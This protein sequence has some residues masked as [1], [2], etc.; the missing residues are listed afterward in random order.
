MV[1]KMQRRT[2]IQV[3]S[4]I[5]LLS[6][7]TILI[8]FIAYY[9]FAAFYAILGISILICVISCILL[10]EQTSAFE[11]CFNYSVLSLFIS[12]VIVAMS[13]FSEDQSFLPY[14]GSMLGIAGIN[15]LVPSLF[16][17]LRNML[18]YGTR[19]DDYPVFYR[20]HSVL[21][22]AIYLVV[23][24]YTAFVPGAVPFAYEGSLT[25][26][27]FAPFEAI[28][29]QIEDYLYGVTTLG[30]IL[31][32]LFCRILL[33]V[34]YG[35]QL[36]L[37]LRRKGR[38]PR[39]LSLLILPGILELA[40]YLFIPSRFDID[41]VIYAFLGGILGSICYYLGN[42]IFRAFTGKDFLSGDSERHYSHSRIH[43]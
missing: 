27:N 5:I 36:T 42:V 4:L 25:A 6:I 18:D 12:L 1:L 17:F 2:N 11:A 41:D 13:F 14:S 30:S 24:V 23:I 9:F 3:S 29:I 34:P 38:L 21:F 33:F 22:F 40:Q 10:T 35:Y 8:Q 16:C 37:S 7:I 20:K 39:L 31:T 19:F 43:F 15:W 28:T 32:Y 26:P